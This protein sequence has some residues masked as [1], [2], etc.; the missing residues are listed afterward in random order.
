[1]LRAD[2][3]LTSNSPQLPGG[4]FATRRTVTIEIWL[5]R[6]EGPGIRVGRMTDDQQ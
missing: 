6:I 2:R 4:R 1:M 5:E 3:I